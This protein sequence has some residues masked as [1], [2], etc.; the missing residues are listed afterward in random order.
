MRKPGCYRDLPAESLWADRLSECRRENL[1]RN[2]SVMLLVERYIYGGHSPMAELALDDVAAREGRAK[3]VEGFGH[4]REFL[5][6]RHPRCSPWPEAAR[7]P[8][9]VPHAAEC[10]S[11]LATD[12][13][14]LHVSE[15]LARLRASRR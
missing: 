11:L 7:S 12:S 8:A 3:P 2:L 10:R 4:A 13:H 9:I 14:Y 15:S 1:Y 5:Q 6:A